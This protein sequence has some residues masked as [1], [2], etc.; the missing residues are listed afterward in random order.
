MPSPQRLDRW[1]LLGGMMMSQ[2]LDFKPS[3]DADRA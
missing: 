1:S 2:N 3:P